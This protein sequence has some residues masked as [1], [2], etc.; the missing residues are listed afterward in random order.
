MTANML[1]WALITGYS[2]SNTC[3]VCGIVSVQQQPTEKSKHR[4]N[5]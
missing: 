2:G 3:A 1:G 5:K 4:S